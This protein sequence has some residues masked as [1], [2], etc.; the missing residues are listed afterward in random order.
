MFTF[1]LFRKA[2]KI[3]YYEKKIN[4]DLHAKMANPSPANLRDYCLIRLAQGIPIADRL[5]FEDYYNPTCKYPSLEKAILHAELGRLKSLQHFILGKTKDPDETIV[6]LLAILINFEPR[7]Y[8]ARDW[9]VAPMNPYKQDLPPKKDSPRLRQQPE[10][11]PQS[12]HRRDSY[13]TIAEAEENKNTTQARKSYVLGA[14]GLIL[15]FALAQY[16]LH[17]RKQ[18]SHKHKKNNNQQ[19]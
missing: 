18:S 7:P 8:S 9:Q 5:V 12:G 13:A 10:D 3:A 15:L 6:K 14:T 17:L 2:V 11:T 16:M 19:V 1:I 4:E